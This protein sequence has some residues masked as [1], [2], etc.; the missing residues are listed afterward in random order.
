LV[1]ENIEVV[2]DMPA[3]YASHLK[4]KNPVSVVLVPQKEGYAGGS[5]FLIKKGKGKF[6]LELLEG[7]VL[8]DEFKKGNDFFNSNTIF[9][10]SK[11]EPV[12]EIA[13]ELKEQ[14]TIARVK[15]N[16]GDITKYNDA[17]GIG[18]RV[19]RDQKMVEYEN[20]KSYDEYG[21]NGSWYMGLFQNSWELTLK[22]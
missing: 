5:P 10:S 22:N 17:S 11:V 18:G 16:M 6:N 21:D 14:N 19:G 13:F 12:D 3:L 2:S 7:S 8:P 9:F 15:L 4:G 20:F 1:F